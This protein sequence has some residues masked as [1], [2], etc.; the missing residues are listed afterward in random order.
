MVTLVSLKHS[1]AGLAMKQGS[2]LH[3]A[4]P[5]SGTWPGCSPTRLVAVVPVTIHTPEGQSYK[6]LHLGAL[7][8]GSTCGQLSDHQRIGIA[9]LAAASAPAFLTVGFPRLQHVSHLMHLRDRDALY[10]GAEEPMQDLPVDV[11]RPATY[12]VHHHGNDSLCDGDC[13][14]AI[15][16]SMASLPTKAFDLNVAVDKNILVMIDPKQSIGKGS[17]RRRRPAV[18]KAA[19]RGTCVANGTSSCDGDEHQCKDGKPEDGRRTA[20]IAAEEICVSVEKEAAPSTEKNLAAWDDRKSLGSAAKSIATTITTVV[21]QIES[22]DVAPPNQDKIQNCFSPN[23]IM[24]PA[25]SPTSSPY[26]SMLLTFSNPAMELAYIMSV[27]AAHA[28]SDVIFCMMYVVTMACYHACLSPQTVVGHGWAAWAG[29]LF[30]APGLP[31]ICAILFLVS[32]NSSWYKSWY[33]Q[34][35]EALFGFLLLVNALFARK[36]RLSFEPLSVVVGVP[37]SL[38]LA[39]SAWISVGGSLVEFFPNV[40]FIAAVALGCRIRFSWLLPLQGITV[41]SMATSASWGAA[42][43]VGRCMMCTLPL[44]MA[45]LTEKSE[46]EIFNSTF[47]S[48]KI[49]IITAVGRKIND[50]DVGGEACSTAA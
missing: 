42:S 28:S 23:L 45:W 50:V 35:R 4:T 10:I 34:Y 7:I 16:V 43:I 2:P 38:D 24:P 11:G 14:D 29:L 41:W 47:Y 5:T 49:G 12:A 30:L 22:I 36:V 9:K 27:S 20:A 19:P 8:L 31:L 33:G 26:T 44:V 15:D 25:S 48:S 46:R 17:R 13:R 37:S 32:E 40:F 3:M 39:K 1:L 18:V 6:P 21:N